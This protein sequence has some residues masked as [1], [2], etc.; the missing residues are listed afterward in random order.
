MLLSP[1]DFGRLLT[2]EQ[3]DITQAIGPAD[4]QRFVL[5]SHLTE[6]CVLRHAD[7]QLL[8]YWPFVCQFYG[9]SLEFFVLWWTESII[10]PHLLTFTTEVTLAKKVQLLWYFFQ[11]IKTAADY[12]STQWTRPVL[13]FKPLT[14]TRFWQLGR[15]CVSKEIS[16]A[17]W[18][19]SISSWLISSS[20]I[21]FQTTT[22]YTARHREQVLTEHSPWALVIFY[23]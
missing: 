16:V 15:Q 13:C 2:I 20:D 12:A 7:F 21:L 9:E 5:S 8:G 6:G 3:A 1:L 10:F 14:W 17:W 18:P 23:N 22:C 19:K 4:G 11:R